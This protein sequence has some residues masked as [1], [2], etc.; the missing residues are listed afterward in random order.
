MAEL[1]LL[2]LVAR[3]PHPSALARRAGSAPLFP[4][5][6]RLERAGLVTRRT[7]LYRL[8]QRGRSE[9]ALALA[10]RASVVRGATA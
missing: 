5:L 3:H 9:L 6:R 10:I 4:A 8:T 2:S 1:T 7:G